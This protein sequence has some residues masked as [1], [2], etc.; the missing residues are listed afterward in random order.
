MF[1]FFRRYQR[2]I[3]FIITGVIILSFSFF[4]TYSAFVSGKGDDPVVFRLF[5]GTPVTRSKC[6][7]Y[8][9]FL[10]TDAQPSEGGHVNLLNDGVFLHDIIETGI[11]ELLVKKFPQ[12]FL[13][14]KGKFR[15]EKSFIPYHH[16]QAP[17]IGALQVW[18]YF[19]PDLKSAFEEYQELSGED[20]VELYRKKT[21][22]FRAERQ[23]SPFYL[24]QVLMHQQK[25]FPWLEPDVSLEHR[26]LGLFGYQQISDW[27]GA[28]F[29]EKACQFIMQV[30]QQAKK[31]GWS[32]SS[33]EVLASLQNNVEKAHRHISSEESPEELFQ[34]SLQNL[35]MDRARAMEVWSHVLLFRRA[36]TELPR[37]VI[38][39]PAVLKKYFQNEE[40]FCEL[41]CFQ[42]QPSLRFST[43]KDLWKFETYLQAVSA[44]KGLELPQTFRSVDSVL[45]SY[46]E[47]VEQRFIVSFSA[48]SID[49]ISKNI[50]LRDIW[51]W[52]DAHWDELVASVD[53]LRGVPATDR[54]KKLAALEKISAAA[55]SHANIIAKEHIVALHPE[56]ID[57]ALRKESPQTVCVGL[58]LKGGVLPFEGITDRQAFLSELLK[59]PIDEAY[60][61]LGRYSQDGQHF[62]SIRVLDKAREQSIVSF[63]DALADGTMDRILDA[64]LEAAY[65]RMKT[66]RSRE[67]KNDDGSW[68]KFSELKEQVG[69]R[70]FAPLSKKLDVLV[71]VWKQK[72]PEYCHWDDVKSARVAVRF[73]PHL[74]LLE[75]RL[76]KEGA[77]APF[78][79]VPFLP[80]D[81][82]ITSL[83]ERPLQDL[84]KLVREPQ[85]VVYRELKEKVAFSGAFDSPVGSWI[86]PRYSQNFGP[87]VA[88]VTAT[89]IGPSD[90]AVRMS[91][92]SLQETLGKETVLKRA[93]QYLDQ[94][95]PEVIS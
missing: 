2:V 8:V 58:R 24:R 46:P 68:K 52:Q 55:R 48:A 66:D 95:Y 94:L 56:W 40:R 14:W 73:L 91:L 84:W 25:Q 51:D 67:W 10:S 45:A 49:H 37:D 53:E 5:D 82:K 61:P 81:P 71:N 38:L 29:V 54:P 13:D 72:L 63:P 41:D 33:S 50:R 30:A 22:L 76:E 9:A 34:I 42:L 35:N 85:K 64:T 39:D 74:D 70:Y 1:T 79:T 28:H 6:N 59:A 88:K 57:E 23:F 12:Q 32:V 89:G 65:E 44:P 21:A 87:F 3:Y 92:Y 26:S 77:E 69:E 31:A 27:Y 75:K 18:S 17:F 60:A 36:L 83:E 80:T 78:V 93:Q 16:P 19:S 4:G 62:Y 11:G 15:R 43:T 90:T 47:L 86:S 20:I 7:D